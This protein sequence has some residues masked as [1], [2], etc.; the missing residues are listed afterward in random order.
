MIRYALA[1]LFTSLS[2]LAQGISLE[3]DP[4]QTTIH[5]TVGSTLHTVH[6]SF[7]LK[8]GIIQFDPAS[9]KASG[10]IVI[11]LASGES[12]N[13]SRDKR[14]HKEI[15][16]SDRFPDATFTPD[17]FEG[18]YLPEGES[19]L[20]VH[21]VFN[22]HG[23]DHELTLPMTVNTKSGE[24][25]AKTQFTIPYLKW[26]FKNPSTFILRVSDHVD[27]EVTA[28]GRVGSGA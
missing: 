20:Q 4:A 18:K 6:G 24:L 13:D 19:Q 12:G 17:R 7:K 1:L 27:M 21:G 9:G 2:V 28:T 10:Q 23:A 15:L 5:F 3:L 16:Q 14:M 26:G 25:V 8:R 22:I 11:D